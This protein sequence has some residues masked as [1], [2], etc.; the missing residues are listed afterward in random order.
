M[1]AVSVTEMKPTKI[2]TVWKVDENLRSH[3]VMDAKGQR[4]VGG[5]W[6]KSAHRRST[7]ADEKR[8]NIVSLML[9]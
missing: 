8:K 5:G 3:Q 9:A 4:R 6:N 1:T 7:S 2:K